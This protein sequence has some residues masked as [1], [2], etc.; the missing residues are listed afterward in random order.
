MKKVFAIGALM[1]TALFTLQPATADM[2]PATSVDGTVITAPVVELPVTEP[3]VA[4]E[5]APVVAAVEPAPVVVA[6]EP[7]VAA[8]VAVVPAT[9]TPAATAVP[10]A[11]ATV[12][13]VVPAP[14]ATAY[15]EG[16]VATATKTL[17]DVL[18]DRCTDAIPDDVSVVRW[19]EWKAAQ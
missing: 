1:V 17:D 7:V 10:E 3:V 16:P 2:S 19:C 12:T 9:V 11:P 13:A 18:V 14:V 15:T 5:P 6:A 4:T 8:P